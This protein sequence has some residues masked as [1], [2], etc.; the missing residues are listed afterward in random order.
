MHHRQ[1]A[2]RP[3]YPTTSQ[4]WEAKNDTV[5]PDL[6]SVVSKPTNSGSDVRQRQPLL[7]SRT[8]NLFDVSCNIIYKVKSCRESDSLFST[9]VRLFC[10]QELSPIKDG[11]L[12]PLDQTGI[13]RGNKRNSHVQ[14]PQFDPEAEKALMAWFHCKI[15]ISSNSICNPYPR[16]NDKLLFCH[17]LSCKACSCLNVCPRYMHHSSVKPHFYS[18]K[19]FVVCLSIALDS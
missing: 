16:S 13:F 15:L 9:L 6:I 7:W 1:L 11:N 10:N 5:T 18:F 14:P 8:P 3:S 12:Q 17:S 2:I 19:Y 4:Q